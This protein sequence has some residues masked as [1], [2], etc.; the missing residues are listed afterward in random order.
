MQNA[1]AD[2]LRG[3]ILEL[4]AVSGE[5]SCIGEIVRMLQRGDVPPQ[6]RDPGGRNDP[7]PRSSTSSASRYTRRSAGPRDHAGS[8]RFAREQH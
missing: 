8:T 5:T 6:L 3:R 7:T 1:I 4:I 2:A